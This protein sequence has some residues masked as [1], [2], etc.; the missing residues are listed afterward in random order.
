MLC[1]SLIRQSFKRF[2]LKAHFVRVQFGKRLQKLTWEEAPPPP[3]L[4]HPIGSETWTFCD[5]FCLGPTSIRP[6][7][8]PFA[9][10]ITTEGLVEISSAVLEYRAT[11]VMFRKENCWHA[12]RVSREGVTER[13]RYPIAAA[14]VG[15]HF[16]YDTFLPVALFISDSPLYNY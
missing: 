11:V 2:L 10:R 14:L 7:T 5:S 13:P 6:R 8:I 1:L 12:L 3:A 9:T 4:Q 16:I 15:R